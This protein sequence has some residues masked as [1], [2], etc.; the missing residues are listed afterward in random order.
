MTNITKKSAGIIVAT[1]I[2]AART[3]TG[4]SFNV[5]SRDVAA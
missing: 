4:S 1:G 3:V 2:K 5:N